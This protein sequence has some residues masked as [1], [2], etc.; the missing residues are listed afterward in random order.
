MQVQMAQWG[1]V[2]TGWVRQWATR[3][4]PAQRP[5]KPLTAVEKP[6]QGRGEQARIEQF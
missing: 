2:G 6:E 5:V 1:F 3:D 4:L